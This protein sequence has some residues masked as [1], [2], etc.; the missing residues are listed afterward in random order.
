MGVWLTVGPAVDWGGREVG[1]KVT[2]VYRVSARDSG[3]KGLS[4][5]D[6]LGVL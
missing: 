1:G 4:V 2:A 6:R 5:L 3:P